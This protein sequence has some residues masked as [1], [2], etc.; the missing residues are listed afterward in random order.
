M[1]EVKHSISSF[2]EQTKRLRARK[3][4]VEAHAAVK[5]RAYN[6]IV[7]KISSHKKAIETNIRVSLD[8]K[9]RIL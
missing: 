2:Q 7:N 1:E 4:R 8:Q 5:K 3:A 9:I 6:D